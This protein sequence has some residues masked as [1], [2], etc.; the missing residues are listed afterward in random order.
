MLI[1]RGNDSTHRVLQAQRTLMEG[2]GEDITQHPH[3]ISQ[4]AGKNAPMSDA[5]RVSMHRLLAHLKMRKAT[6]RPIVRPDGSKR[7]E[8]IPGTRFM[9]RSAP[10]SRNLGERPGTSAS[11]AGGAV[12]RLGREQAGAPVEKGYDR[13]ADVETAQRHYASLPA[14]RR[15]KAPPRAQ[16]LSQR[17]NVG[18][19][20]TRTARAIQTMKAR[21]RP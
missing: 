16:R 21:R 15:G 10:R 11:K 12:A 6:V 18:G 3:T 5:R 19:A 1:N 9:K 8:H 13:A 20:Q 14:V 17:I 7:I 4:G 2:D